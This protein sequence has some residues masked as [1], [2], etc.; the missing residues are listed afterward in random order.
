MVLV[1]IHHE[2][3]HP[4]YLRVTVYEDEDSAALALFLEIITECINFFKSSPQS[5]VLH[6][7]CTCFPVCVDVGP[8]GDVIPVL[9]LLDQLVAHDF[10]L[11]SEDSMHF[12]VHSDF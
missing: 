5:I 2:R 7:Q 8:Q 11:V 4:I 1:G 3:G 6:R 10:G 9:K 12:T